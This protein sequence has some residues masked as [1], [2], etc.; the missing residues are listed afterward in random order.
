MNCLFCHQEMWTDECK[1]SDLLL[2]YSCTSIAC[3]V[4]NDFPRYIVGTDKEEKVCWQEYAIGNFYLKVNA[5]E[6]SIYKLI[7]CMLDDEVKVP[8]P[9]W[10]NDINSD[11]TLDKVRGLHYILLT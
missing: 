5:N 8:Y 2:K 10:L 11:R 1:D 9:L 4:N 6:T 7:A 3:M